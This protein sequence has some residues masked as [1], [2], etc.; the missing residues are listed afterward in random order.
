MSLNLSDYKDIVFDPKSTYIVAHEGSYTYRFNFSKDLKDLIRK[1][2][3]VDWGDGTINRE[4]CHQYELPESVDDACKYHIIK[5]TGDFSGADDESPFDHFYTVGAL[6]VGTNVKAKNLFNGCVYLTD[7]DPDLFI[8]RPDIKN[9]DSVFYYCSR[10]KEIP[11]N[12]FIYCRDA[13]NFD[14][15]FYGCFDLKSIPAGLF[16]TNTK[17][18][19]F[20]RTFAYCE[21]LESVS[22]DLFK[23]CTKLKNLHYCF[24][25]CHRIKDF[26]KFKYSTD[27]VRRAVSG[28]LI[29]DEYRITYKVDVRIQWNCGYWNSGKCEYHYFVN[30][31]MTADELKDLLNGDDFKHHYSIFF[32]SLHETQFFNDQTES[33]FTVTA[34]NVKDTQLIKD[35]FEEEKSV[36]LTRSLFK[37]DVQSFK[38]YVNDVILRGYY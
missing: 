23:S 16:E 35:D 31:D 24:E 1:N 37:D 13:K 19:S 36:R 10:L 28:D 17:A 18:E 2:P 5:I 9:F 29:S 3:L 6:R 25:G 8:N 27:S 11:E 32:F 7:L 33:T 22:P 12:L 30:S 15:A 26:P 14:H 4:D 38:N 21:M 20:F 34:V